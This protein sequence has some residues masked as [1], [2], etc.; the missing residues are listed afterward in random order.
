MISI[1]TKYVIGMPEI[2]V[3]EP[4]EKEVKSIHSSKKS[5]IIYSGERGTGRSILLRKIEAN[6]IGKKNQT[7]FIAPEQ[8]GTGRALS[9]EILDHRTELLFARYMIWYVKH[10][11]KDLYEKYLTHELDLIQRELGFFDDYMNKSWYDDSIDIKCRC[12]T[13]DLSKYILGRIRDMLEV[14]K[15]NLAIDNFDGI[16]G[17]DEY[18]QKVYARYF[19]LFDKVIL[20]SKDPNL[21]K[22]RLTS[23][24]YD[25]RKLEYGMDKNILGEIIKRRIEYHNRVCANQYNLDFCTKPEFIEDLAKMGP[26][27]SNALSIISEIETLRKWYIESNVTSEKIFKEAVEKNEKDVLTLKA[28]D[29]DPKFAL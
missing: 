28:R 21:D 4:I 24:G 16:S 18:L 1:N 14:E 10:N 8:I 25:I 7:I 5:R 12:K 6:G 17:S 19:D 26:N 2:L 29:R 11:Y 3:K 27:I 22:D 13:K 23:E 9:E 15:L 20:V